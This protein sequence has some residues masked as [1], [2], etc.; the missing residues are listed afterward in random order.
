MLGSFAFRVVNVDPK[1]LQRNAALLGEPSVRHPCVSAAEAPVTFTAQSCKSRRQLAGS[2]LDQLAN[3]VSRV[4]GE[5][6]RHIC[7]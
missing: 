3:S 4:S 1:F 7:Q 5:E 2:Q 6:R